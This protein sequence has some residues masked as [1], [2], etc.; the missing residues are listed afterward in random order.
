MKQENK[1]YEWVCKNA[2]LWNEI[3][4]QGQLDWSIFS[5]LKI[6]VVTSIFQCFGVLDT[7]VEE[8]ERLLCRID[9][10]VNYDLLYNHHHTDGEEIYSK[11]AYKAD[12]ILAD[13]V[14]DRLNKRT[15]DIVRDRLKKQKREED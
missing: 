1:V 14:C 2:G 7:D 3:S 9:W 11:S 12:V 10:S 15:A 13:L 5:S 4:D 6:N 8:V